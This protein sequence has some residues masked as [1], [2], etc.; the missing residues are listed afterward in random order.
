[1]VLTFIKFLRFGLPDILDIILV[2]LILYWLFRWLKGTVAINILAGILCFYFLWKIVVLFHLDLLSEILG[3]FLNVGMIALIIIF[4][5][6]IRKFFLFIGNNK[7]FR[8]LRLNK[9][10][11]NNF[12]SEQIE[13]IVS[14]CKNMSDSRTGALIVLTRENP[15]DDIV[16]TGESIN[17]SISREL[18]ETIFFKNT[19]LHDGALIIRNKKML[20]AR[21][22]LPVSQ[23][24]NIPSHLGLRHRASIGITENTDCYT[25]IV[26]EQTGNISYCSEGTIHENIK[27]KGLRELL[28]KEFSADN[29]DKRK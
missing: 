2:T 16:H 8:N 28:N 7:F 24:G 19:P 10:I 17:A 13:N 21:C 3:Q 26:S 6:E 18:I 11:S 25:V 22:I 27:E 23:K 15:L 5:P 20:A 9:N 1:M 14:A 29:N 4:Q 12:D